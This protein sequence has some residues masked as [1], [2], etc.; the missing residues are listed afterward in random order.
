MNK[1][2]LVKQNVANEDLRINTGNLRYAMAL[3]KED[4]TAQITWPFNVA[5]YNNLSNRGYIKDPRTV[6]SRVFLWSR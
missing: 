2:S 4:A 5:F 1:D 6:H 3:A